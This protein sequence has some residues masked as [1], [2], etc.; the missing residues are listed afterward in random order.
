[1][2]EELLK[3][4]TNLNVTI[5][6]ILAAIIAFMFS[7]RNSLRGKGL[8]NIEKFYQRTIFFLLIIFSTSVI[9][10]I[11]FLTRIYISINITFK[12]IDLFFGI[13]L[14]LILPLVA[15]TWIFLYRKY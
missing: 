3:F 12:E 4:L 7:A 11:Y 9:S 5:S 13:I 1:M 2:N 8:D 15:V 14:I 10:L 6:S